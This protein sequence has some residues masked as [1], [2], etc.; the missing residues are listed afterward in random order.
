MPTYGETTST[1][2]IPHNAT[3][4][5]D[6]RICLLR[7]GRT[8]LLHRRIDR[9]YVDFGCSLAH[10]RLWPWCRLV[11]VSRM[12][13]LCISVEMFCAR[14]QIHMCVLLVWRDVGCERWKGDLPL[15]RHSYGGHRVK[16][17]RA[18]DWLKY[19][20]IFKA[21]ESPAE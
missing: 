21:V 6:T 12:Y 11:S 3:P 4:A 16:V 20:K 7:G 5:T 10:C 13:V 17:S 1:L 15:R 8:K 9:A 19:D 18:S 2:H 14:R